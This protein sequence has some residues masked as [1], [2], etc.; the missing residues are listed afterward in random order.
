MFGFKK[1]EAA[2]LAEIENDPRS[3][4]QLADAIQVEE[5]NEFDPDTLRRLAAKDS[6]RVISADSL[7]SRGD[8]VD[9]DSV[10]LVDADDGMVFGGER[11][12]FRK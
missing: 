11:N 3:L 5:V 8:D 7:P 1:S 6:G 10:G 4:R 12:F 2:T 9:W